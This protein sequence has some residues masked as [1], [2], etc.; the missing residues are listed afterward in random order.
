MRRRGVARVCL[1]TVLVSHLD[2][3][4]DVYVCMCIFVFDIVCVT[5]G[6]CVVVCVFGVFLFF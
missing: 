1:E 6:C 4:A 2:A 3:D 5:V